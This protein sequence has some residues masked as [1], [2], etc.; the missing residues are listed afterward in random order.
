MSEVG[1]VEMREIQRW[2]SPHSFQP[3]RLRLNA[4][5]SVLIIQ[6]S[7]L[8]TPYYPILTAPYFS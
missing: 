5:F 7:L 6:S 1:W 2:N 8:L 4:N 3:T